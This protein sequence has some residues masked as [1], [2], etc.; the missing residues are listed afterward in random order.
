[1]LVA[2]EKRFLEEKHEVKQLIENHRLIVKAF[3]A[4]D[5]NFIKQVLQGHFEDTRNTVKNT[6]VNHCEQ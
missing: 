1:M 5:I 6:F 4:K 2:T 3:V